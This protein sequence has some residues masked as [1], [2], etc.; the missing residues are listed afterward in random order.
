MFKDIYL[1][2]Y[3]KNNVLNIYNINNFNYGLKLKI[4]NLKLQFFF[5]EKKCNTW[6][7]ITGNEIKEIS[8]EII[9]EKSKIKQNNINE[10]IYK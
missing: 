1:I 6:N 8:F 9:N 4:Y 3:S 7:I 10:N 2:I 5:Y